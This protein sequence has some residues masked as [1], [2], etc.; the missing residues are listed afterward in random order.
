MKFVLFFIYIPHQIHICLGLLIQ[1]LKASILPFLDDL[2]PF[3]EHVWVCH[4]SAYLN[5]LMNI[6]ARI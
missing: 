3:V 6:P 5:F 2:L 1:R 4:F